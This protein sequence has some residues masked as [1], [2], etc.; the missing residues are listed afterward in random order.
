MSCASAL[1]AVGFRV[2][3]SG[4]MWVHMGLSGFI[5]FIWVY[6][7][8][9][10]GFMGFRV[11]VSQCPPKDVVVLVTTSVILVQFS[12]SADGKAAWRRSLGLQRNPPTPPYVEPPENC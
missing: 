9:I 8:F 4:F 6:R 2:L 11:R 12:L 3:Y 7:G 5:G 10:I 1:E